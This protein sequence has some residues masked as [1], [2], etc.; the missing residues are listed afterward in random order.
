MV[1]PSWTNFFNKTRSLEHLSQ[2]PFAY[3]ELF[4]KRRKPNAIITSFASSET[5]INDG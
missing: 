5:K 2:L 4:S 1:I 3:I